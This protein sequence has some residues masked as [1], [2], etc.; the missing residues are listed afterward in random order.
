MATLYEIDK[1]FNPRSPCGE[2]PS[3]AGRGSRPVQ[4]Q[5]TLPVR[6]ATRQQLLH[7][8]PQRISIHAPRAGSDMPARSAP[9][10]SSYFNP[11][12]PCGER[13]D[14]LDYYPLVDAFQSTLPVRG[15][16][17]NFGRCERRRDYFNPRSPCGE[18]RKIHGF[19]QRRHKEISIH[20]PRAGS[21][22]RWGRNNLRGY[23]FQSTL[24]VRGATNGDKP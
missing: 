10:S 22:R 2:R 7:D 20:A 9:L 23:Q 21:D 11:R 14:V 3:R 16:T 12:S 17:P 13:L 24:P 8:M 1:D 15:A 4:F 5:S 18:R 6:G 19:D